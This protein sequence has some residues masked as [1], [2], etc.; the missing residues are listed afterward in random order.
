MH[1]VLIFTCSALKDN[2]EHRPMGYSL[3]NAVASE[4]RVRNKWAFCHYI[5]EEETGRRALLEVETAPLAMQPR[6]TGSSGKL[7]YGDEKGGSGKRVCFILPQTSE[8][9]ASFEAKFRMPCR[10]CVD[11]TG[12]IRPGNP[13]T[14]QTFKL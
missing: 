14:F 10:W 8:I 11:T 6:F 1:V 13:A 7:G 12:V 3:F 4:C 2:L 9:E 5:Q